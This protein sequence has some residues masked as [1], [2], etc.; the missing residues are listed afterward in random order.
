[1]VRAE[2]GSGWR[3]RPGE[4]LVTG[5]ATL[6]LF[7]IIWLLRRCVGLDD[8][9]LTAGFLTFY[10]AYVINDPHF[11]VTYVLFYKDARRRTFDSSRSISQR[12]RYGFSA[13]VVPAV[14]I[15]WVSAAM[16]AH[17]ATMLGWMIQLMYLTVGWHYVKQ[18]F[19]VLTVLSMRRNV[20]VT[21]RERIVILLH[22]Y[23]AWAFAWANPV[24]AGWGVR[25]KGSGLQRARPSARS[26]ARDGVGAGRVHA[27]NG[28]RSFQRSPTRRKVSSA[29]S[30]HGSDGYG[31]ALDHFFEPRPGPALFIPALHALQ[32]FYFVGLMKRN[33]ARAAE[34]P[35]TF[36]KPV[37]VRL[38][39][40]ALTALA[41]GWFLFRGAPT[42]LDDWL[43][44][45]V[46]RGQIPDDLGETPYFAAFFVAVSIHHYFMDSVI[47]RRD[48]PDTRYFKDP[49]PSQSLRF[50]K[51]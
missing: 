32:Y 15:T 6:V 31:L 46:R 11:A 35:P 36:G 48:N 44:P 26:R 18:G 25:R 30:L 10:G 39:V 3:P 34:G 40:L 4:F 42:V 41:L 24:S 5:G 37:A 2:E 27:G 21:K 17:S 8:A 38:G 20:R 47:W 33:E 51:A 22:C 23:A 9:E 29:R 13:I 43:T 12:V 28:G 14:L 1:M 16:I 45:K 49:S 7:P 50:S 19:G